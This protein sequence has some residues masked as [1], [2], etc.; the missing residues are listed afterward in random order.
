MRTVAALLL[1]IALAGCGTGGGDAKWEDGRCNGA[2]ALCD[3]RYD[4]VS[5]PT[6]H[7]AMSSADAMWVAPNQHHGIA[8]QL[9]DGVRALMLDV[10]SYEGLPQLCHG[11]CLLGNRPRAEGLADIADFLADSPGEV[12]TIIF[13]TYVTAAAT[14]AAFD[15]AG[16]TRFLHTQAKGAPWPTLREMITANRR[17]VVFTDDVGAAP[18]PWYLDVW[19]FAWETPYSAETTTDFTCAKNRGDMANSL[20]ILNHFLG[21]PLPDEALALEANPA[22]VLGARAT[23]CMTQSGRLPNFVTVDFYDVGDVLSVVDGLN[24]VT[25]AANSP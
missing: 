17:L 2:A 5:Y 25:R 18:P 3:R 21:R 8:R 23:A 15:E 10:H 20:F 1:A 14:A 22:A 7:N 12:V 6:T 24:G 4:Q 13:E 11:S 19:S 9:A 16:A